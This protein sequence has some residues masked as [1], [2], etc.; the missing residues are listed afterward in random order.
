QYSYG[1]PESL[2]LYVPRLFGGSGAEDLGRDSKVY[3]YL[4][5]QGLAGGQALE[6]SGNLPLYWG[7]QPIVAGPAYVGAIVLFL[8]VL[9]LVLVKGKTKWWLLLGALLSLLLSWGKNF[10]LLTDLMID[11]FPLYNKFRAV[12]SIQVVLELCLPVLGILGLWQLFRGDLGRGEKLKALKVAFFSCFGLG[13]LILAL[14][15]GFDFVGPR[16]EMY[17]GYYGQEL[18]D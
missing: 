13:A 18:M 14:K 8:F 11:H 15:G 3:E 7:E 9:G 1:V 16:D 17:L 5:G 12:S 10:P 2:N 4:T 6:L